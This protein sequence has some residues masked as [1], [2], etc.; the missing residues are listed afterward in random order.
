MVP[1]VVPF[2]VLALPHGVAAAM[3]MARG[4]CGDY[5]VGN[6]GAHLNGLTAILLER[7]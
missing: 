4:A 1:S 2:V 6:P 5:E 7:E 3:A